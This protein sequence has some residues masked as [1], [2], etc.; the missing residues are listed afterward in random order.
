MAVRR[1]MVLNAATLEFLDLNAPTKTQSVTRALNAPGSIDVSLPVEYNARRDDDGHPWLLEGG[2]L[3]VAEDTAGRLSV[4][5]ADAVTLEMDAVRVSAGG[6]TMLAKG[7]PWDGTTQS[8]ISMDALAGWR[9]IWE[10]LNTQPGALAGEVLGDTTC[11]VLVGRPESDS[12]RSVRLRIEEQQAIIDHA[13][14][15]IAEMERLMTASALSMYT[16][17]GLKRVGEV[18]VSTS[19]P[20]G[21]GGPYASHIRTDTHNNVVSVHFWVQTSGTHQWATLSPVTEARAQ[22]YLDRRQQKEGAEERKQE[23]EAIKGPLE[24]W[25]KRV[26]PNSH[27]EPYELNWWSTHDLSRN[28]EELRDM[29]GF[30]W[31][32]TCRLIGNTIQPGVKAARRAGALRDDLRFEIG[33]NV[34]TLPGLER[35]EIHTEIQAFGEGEGSAMLHAE[36]TMRHPRL[37]RRPFVVQAKDASTQQLVD[38]AADKALQ[39]AQRALGYTITD[40][41]VNDHDF[42]PPGSYDLGDIVPFVGTLPDGS[43]LALMVRVMEITDDGGDALILKVETT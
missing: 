3:L 10:H 40:L 17:A 15:G 1:V 34:H 39:D 24:E 32:E 25:V 28:L 12:Y 35:G 2:T 38:R 31:W 9:Q 20:S 22:V 5:L 21:D 18:S 29:G 42:A 23:A 33:I 30:D 43:R 13:D 14:R 36:R 8:W 37:V 27:A 16:A 6:V 7:A 11:G 41:V 19:A 26:L 4:G